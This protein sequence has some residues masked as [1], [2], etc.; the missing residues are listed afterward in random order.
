MT[1][2]STEVGSSAVVRRLLIVCLTQEHMMNCAK[3]LRMSP[4]DLVRV[5]D[6]QSLYGF[7]PSFGPLY[8]LPDGFH[9]WDWRDRKDTLGR[10]GALGGRIIY[11]REDQITVDS[12]PWPN[13]V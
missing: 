8:V 9:N 2:P 6:P 10:W 4:R 1:T 11:V 12:F 3:D 13:V 5:T 7:S